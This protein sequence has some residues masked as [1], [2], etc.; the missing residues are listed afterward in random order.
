MV[1]FRYRPTCQ[2]SIQTDFRPHLPEQPALPGTRLRILTYS[3][4]TSTRLVHHRR[5]PMNARQRVTDLL[6]AHRFALSSQHH[7]QRV[8]CLIG[9]YRYQ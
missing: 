9:Q 4:T 5:D 6:P 1:P 7:P 8:D 3:Q 2:R